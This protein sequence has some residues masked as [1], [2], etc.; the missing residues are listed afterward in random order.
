MLVMTPRRAPILVVLFA[1][2]AIAGQ[3]AFPAS[4]RAAQYMLV[5]M[6]LQ[7]TDHLKAYGLAYYALTQ[8]LV[9]EWVLN[10]RGGSFAIPAADFLDRK[11]RLLGRPLEHMDEPGHDAMTATVHASNMDSSRLEKAPRVA[12]YTPPNKQPWDDA[13]TLALTYAE[14][15]Y[16]TLW[17]N[18]VLAGQLAEYDWLHLHHEDFTG[19]F[20]KFFASFR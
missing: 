7:Q 11:A 19:Q 4:V 15:P 8:G 5:P 16:A 13:V 18:E 17:D 2:A 12:I 3:A 6:D 9:V 20:G 14:I 10:Y 1:V